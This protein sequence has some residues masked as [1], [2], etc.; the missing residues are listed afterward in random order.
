MSN[1]I[2][3]SEKTR[4]VNLI[5]PPEL[6]RQMDLFKDYA[7]DRGMTLS[8]R[9]RIGRD[10]LC[11]AVM[12]WFVEQPLERKEAIM[13]EGIKIVKDFPSVKKFG[14]IRRTV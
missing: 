7:Q 1:D 4:S 12:A 2:P 9:Q 3:P 11:V 13:Q 6:W 10:G 5:V 14:A 8:S